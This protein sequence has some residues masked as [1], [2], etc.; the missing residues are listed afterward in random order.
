MA[1]CKSA[2]SATAHWERRRGS[3][4]QAISYCSKAATREK[5]PFEF[6]EPAQQG[7]RNDIEALRLDIQGGII[8]KEVLL[9][10]HANVMCKYPRFYSQCVDTYFK[11]GWRDVECILLVGKTGLGK[12][13]WVYDNW[14]SKS[15]WRLP[16]VTTSCWFDGYQGQ[17]H[18]LLDDFAG[19]Q[20]KISVSL[21]LQ[22]L[23]GY[24]QRMPVKGGFCG[25]NPV[26]IAITSN[27]HPNLWYQWSTRM[28]QYKALER[29][30][31]VVKEFV[32]HDGVVSVKDIEPEEYFQYNF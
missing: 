30:F 12:T 14:L 15:F 32:R 9:E 22:L 23:D 3:A 7:K 16:A 13:R 24:S 1:A 2:C 20:S 11:D 29:R 26:H 6:G 27:L 18:V 10:D 8:R 21:L 19:A 25:W 17:T 31:T 4:K 5:G 28:T